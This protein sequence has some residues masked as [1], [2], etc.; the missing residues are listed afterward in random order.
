VGLGWLWGVARM[1][2]KCVTIFIVFLVVVGVGVGVW[3]L[4][5][6]V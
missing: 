1:K 4:G 6:V 3:G 2:P 5:A